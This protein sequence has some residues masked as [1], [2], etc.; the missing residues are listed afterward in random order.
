[1]LHFTVHVCTRFTCT[2]Y[3]QTLTFENV[4]YRES[5]I[6]REG[7]RERERGNYYVGTDF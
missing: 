3:T 5:E 6:E 4:S 7:E 1:M 2:Q